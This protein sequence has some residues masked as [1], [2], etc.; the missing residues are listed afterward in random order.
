MQETG[1]RSLPSW[2]YFDDSTNTFLGVPTT[3]DEG[4]TSIDVMAHSMKYHSTT[5]F[6]I[7]VKPAN[8]IHP[9]WSHDAVPVKLFSECDVEQRN[10][11][12]CSW[13]EVVIYTTLLLEADMTRLSAKQRVDVFCKLA[14]YL[15]RDARSITF[16]SPKG[17]HNRVLVAGPGNV[18]IGARR[19]IGAELSWISGCG[20]FSHSGDVATVMEMNIRSGKLTESIGFDIVGWY[21][22]D[23]SPAPRRMKRR[24]RGTA[25]PTNTPQPTRLPSFTSVV[26]SRSSDVESFVASETVAPSSVAFMSTFIA[27]SP[28]ASIV[29]TSSYVIPVVSSNLS[30]VA[31]LSSA[32]F[33]TFNTF[34]SPTVTTHLTVQSTEFFT[35]STAI[36]VMSVSSLPVF[37][38]SSVEVMTPSLTGSSASSSPSVSPSLL[39]PLFS[40]QISATSTVSSSLIDD[41]HSTQPMISSPLMS[42]PSFSSA[43]SIDKTMSVSATPSLQFIPDSTFDPVSSSSFS[44]DSVTSS[45]Y[46]D[47]SSS[48][49]VSTM[50]VSSIV[51]TVPSLVISQMP[52]TLTMLATTASIQAS[53]GVDVWTSIDIPHSSQVISPSTFEL[54]STDSQSLSSSDAAVMTQTVSMATNTALSTPVITEVT[55]DLYSPTSSVLSPYT[56]L[57]YLET[58]S[59]GIAFTY[60]PTFSS[61]ASLNTSVYSSFYEQQ[62]SPQSEI[63]TSFFFPS[64]ASSPDVAQSTVFIPTDT[65]TSTHVFTSS[66]ELSSIEGFSSTI[67]VVENITTTQSS[68]IIEHSSHVTTVSTVQLTP[69]DVETSYYA[70]MTISPS[71]PFDTFTTIQSTPSTDF[72]PEFS[73]SLPS[74]ISTQFLTIFPSPSTLVMGLTEIATPGS[75]VSSIVLTSLLPL[76]TSSLIVTSIAGVL[77]L[78]TSSLVVASMTSAL[79]G[80]TS[81]AIASLSSYFTTEPTVKLTSST[82]QKTSTCEFYTSISVGPK[83]CAYFY[84][85]NLFWAR[86]LEKSEFWSSYIT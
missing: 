58:E 73:S 37:P 18:A 47:A 19:T 26:D 27:A 48:V 13:D 35:K 21:V 77:P 44:I 69:S 72:Y 30:P 66:L 74:L 63:I 82:A 2:V 12:I 20:D 39:S 8:H 83:Y 38:T 65:V 1:R 56:S 76:E 16:T 46:I 84:G 52:S 68:M 14:C 62:S 71:V 60:S 25:M 22:W 28:S 59:S 70:P 51:M 3:K 5:S 40:T 86:K 85:I 4:S 57:D 45:A 7:D 43:T 75:S 6:T 33:S 61:V 10:D 67:V 54:T 34:T 78:E 81:N 55:S 49:D 64:F 50:E 29:A 9:A 32:Q 80:E 24:I 53:S 23:D 79:P 41:Q 15:S 42:S 36:P 17:Q 11:V 31:T